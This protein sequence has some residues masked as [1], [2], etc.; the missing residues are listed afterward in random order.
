MNSIDNADLINQISNGALPT[1]WRMYGKRADFFDIAKRFDID[2]VIARVIRNRDVIGDEAIRTYL[3]G[4]L[5]DTHDPAL[6]KDMEKGCM[7]LSEKIRQGKHIRIISDY[8]VDG[9]ISNYILYKGLNRINQDGTALIDYDI[10]NRIHDGYGMNIRLVQA[11]YDAGVDTILTCDNG[12]AAFEAIDYAKELGMTVIVTDHHEVP[13]DFDTDGNHIYRIVAADAVID[14]KQPDCNYPCKELCGAGVAYKLIQLLYRVNGIPDKECEM[15]IEY[16]GIATVCDVMSLVDENRI[17]VRKALERLMDSANP[18]LRALIRCSKRDNKRLTVFDLGFI[19][20][21]CI[22]AAGRLE[23]ATTSLQFLLEEDSFRAEERAIELV[24]INNQRKNMTLEGTNTAIRMLETE[25][26]QATL[27]DR[28]LVM[29]LPDI[30]ESLLGIIAGRIK[31]RYYRPVLLFSDSEDANIIKGSGRSIEGYHMYDELNK[32]RDYF[33]KFGGHEMAAGFS[34]ERDK[35][36][37]LRNALNANCTMDEQVLTPKLYIDVPMP[38]SYIS[39]DFVKQLKLL[40]PFGKG[41]ES[42]VFAERKVS[43][44]KAVVLG[45]NQNVLRISFVMDNGNMIE[46]I[47]FEPEAF[48]SHIKEWF[49]KDECDRILKGM[50]NHVVLDIAYYPEINEYAGRSNLQIR[51]LEYRR[52]QYE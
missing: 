41:N 43:V 31:E 25:S 49:G 26:T 17:F 21:P 46:G 8:D 15:F 12:I 24:N 2:P 18:G 28:V 47:Y 44:K 30:H 40:A 10:P 16:L 11:A 39:M 22:N 6:M 1:E 37:R 27:R 7:I 14:H 29:Y 48:I 3:Q 51:I 33:T 19:I 32:C 34:M 45:K 20:G 36:D 5:Q 35:L 38:L 52:Y 42:P 50:S 4:D 23:D 13:Y 9:V